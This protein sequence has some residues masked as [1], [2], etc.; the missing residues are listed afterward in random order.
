[1][2]MTKA[3][4]WLVTPLPGLPALISFDAT[5]YQVN[6][7]MR[8]LPG[9]RVVLAVEGDNGA[10][11]L[12]LFKA[13]G[14]GQKEYQRELKAH[15]YCHD[16]QIN[17]PPIVASGS[18]Q[19][20][21]SLILYK[22][23]ESEQ[24]LQDSAID[25]APISALF[26]L[27]ARCH[28]AGCYQADAHLNNFIWSGK[29]MTMLDL[30]SVKIHT[31]ALGQT[32]SLH[33]LAQLIVQW[34]E[35]A[36]TGL[37]K[38]VRSYF[39]LRG[40]PDS[41]GVWRKLQRQITIARQTRLRHFLKKQ[42]RNCSMTVFN[43]SC[44]FEAAWRR[45]LEITPVFDNIR[46]LEDKV[47][48]GSAVK[49]G[50]SATLVQHRLA[51]QSVIIKRYNIKSPGHFMRRCLR[52]S[53]AR[54]SW[55]NANLLLHIGI[56]T[57][58]P[59]GYVEARWCFLRHK[60]FFVCAYVKGTPLDKIAPEL[61]LSSALLEQ[62]ATLFEKLRLYRISHGDMKAS[63]LLVDEHNQLWL[64]DLD[65]MRQLK[66]Q[67][68]EKMHQR[69]RQRFLANWPSGGALRKQLAESLQMTDKGSVV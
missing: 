36:Q 50:H 32:K 22:R 26:E 42:H 11:I 16:R 64:I 21:V 44:Q 43:T 52:R 57:P 28:N 46:M 15:R 29:Q 24:T 51:E 61:L 55:M 10:F 33:N 30:A 17:V 18:H 39:A 48:S 6:E 34:P 66:P 67:R 7:V 58:E 65:A 45:C 12:K 62:I 41:A 68:A 69:D 25:S 23:I 35:D 20:Q 56:K 47:A 37:L 59:L 31:K 5:Q 19:S 53:R 4:Q 27:F 9:R 8:L 3:E 63:N 1:M 38:H 49:R 40:W 14:K 60:A 13:S 54:Q 2:I